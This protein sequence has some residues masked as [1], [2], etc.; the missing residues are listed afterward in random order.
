MFI[1]AVLLGLAGSVLFIIAIFIQILRGK[2]CTGLLAGFALCLVLLLGGGYMFSITDGVVSPA[3]KKPASTP[4]SVPA[5]TDKAS[6]EPVHSQQPEVK[7]NI[8]E[9]ENDIP[10]PD[11]LEPSGNTVPTSDPNASGQLG[12]YYVEIKDAK[13]VKDY[14][15]KSAIVI[16]YSWTNNS[17]KTT[18]AEIALMEKAFQD[19]I[20]LD[21]VYVGDSSKF[22]SDLSFKEIRP[23]TSLDVQCVFELPNGHS[24]VEFELSEFLGWSDDVVTKDFDPTALI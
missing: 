18:S 11:S 16:T 4:K 24:V 23:G 17:E 15:N 1:F 12:D 10:Q 22:D 8:P 9:P 21:T 3:A 14:E 19:G 13:I 2:N 20:Q 5:A 7:E 6:Q